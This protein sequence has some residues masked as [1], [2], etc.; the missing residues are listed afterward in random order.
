MRPLV[1]LG[2][3]VL[4]FTSTGHLGDA[5]PVEGGGDL[6][7]MLSAHWRTVVLYT[8]LDSEEMVE[9]WMRREGL[10]SHV[11]ILCAEKSVAN[12]PWT[13]KGPEPVRD[14]AASWKIQ[15]L[16][17]LRTEGNRELLYV[18]TDP[19]AVS[20]AIRDGVPAMLLAFPTYISPDWRPDTDISPRPW[21]DLA[22]EIE[23]QRDGRHT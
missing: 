11:G 16:R 8:G 14:R 13:L 20:K 21:D 3:D 17:R 9:T 1:L 2:W 10:R 4:G 18:D 19:T 7:R 12:Y 15:Q 5:S 23:L 22:Q 6:Y